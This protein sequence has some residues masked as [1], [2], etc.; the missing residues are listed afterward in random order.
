M[1][2]SVDPPQDFIVEEIYNRSRVFLCAS[3][4]EGFGFPSVEAMACGAALVTTAN[5]GSADYA[6]DG[7]T[8]LVC[9]P[10][11]VT[12]L[13]DCVERLV[14]E[15]ELRVRIA[16]RGME[17]VREHFNWDSSA[18]ELE[19]VLGAYATEPERYGRR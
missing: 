11:D 5:G 6:I 16:T 7:E 10:G 3:R 15:D 8:A 14:S 1:A 19:S 12:A 13:T 18:E 2:V 4:Y 9:E 17:F